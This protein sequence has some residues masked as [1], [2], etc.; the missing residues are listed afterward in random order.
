[1]DRIVRRLAVAAS[2][3]VAGLVANGCGDTA[4]PRPAVEG[5]GWSAEA[6]LCGY[7]ETPDRLSRLRPGE[8]VPLGDDPAG[9]LETARCTS[10]DDR[11]GG[12]GLPE[13][14]FDR[15]YFVVFTGGDRL[16][17]VLVE[18]DADADPVALVVE[19]QVV[20]PGCGQTDDYRG[21]LMLLIEGPADATTPT[22]RL[23]EVPLGC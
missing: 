2:F 22:V 15:P 3:G 19:H 21:Q 14:E 18:V 4:T 16:D 8:V 9:L 5:G 6:V 12:A 10:N 13:I 1:M 17:V 7:R 11:A 23:K 20:G